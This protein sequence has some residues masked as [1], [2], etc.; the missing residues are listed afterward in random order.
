MYYRCSFKKLAPIPNRANRGKLTGRLYPLARARE[1]KHLPTRLSSSHF[2]AATLP[3]LTRPP[4][5]SLLL[6]RPSLSPHPLPAVLP[7]LHL[8]LPPS[9]LLSVRCRKRR[10]AIEPSPP[11]DPASPPPNLVGGE[12]ADSGDALP[13]AGC[14]GRGDGRRWRTREGGGRQAVAPE[15]RRRAESGGALPPPPSRKKVEQRNPVASPALPSPPLPS[16]HCSF[17]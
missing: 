13:S 17:L 12:V 9:V 16:L 3:S 2:S 8:I 1:E 4:P 15:G 11:L 6:Y 14:G 10:A 7:F 5:P